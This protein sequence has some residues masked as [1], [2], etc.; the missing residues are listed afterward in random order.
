LIH[1]VSGKGGV[2]KS[3]VAASLAQALSEE[4]R[5]T[6]LVELGGSHFFEYIYGEK[7]GFEPTELRPGL[8]LSLWDGEACLKEYLLYLLKFAKIV[9][10]FFDNTIMQAL[11][12][13]APGLKE[14]ALTGKITSRERKIGPE[15]PYDDLV[16]DAYSTGH[17]LALLSAP[18]AMAKAISIGPMGAQSRSVHQVLS[19][20]VCE[21]LVV[22]N[23]EELPLTEGE[24][25]AAG[26]DAQVGRSAKWVKNRWWPQLSEPLDQVP[27]GFQE[28]WK[29]KLDLQ[30]QF[31]SK[32]LRE[33]AMVL[34]QIWSH[35]NLEKIELLT[36]LWKSKR[37]S[38]GDL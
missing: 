20:E 16:I 6:L 1:F 7:I 37:E 17:F 33:T 34:P 38:G 11:V 28:N 12:H 21:Y 15:L 5:R 23:P 32:S 24:E 9:D 3:L 36:K 4:G 27:K 30:N 18:L 2:G 31:D 26:I 35:S 13:G 14:L 19:S 10:L 8:S 29:R 25:L 22:V